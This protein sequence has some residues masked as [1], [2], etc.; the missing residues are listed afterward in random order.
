VKLVTS[1]SIHKFL[2]LLTYSHWYNWLKTVALASPKLLLLVTFII[3]TVKS[4]LGIVKNAS[5]SSSFLFFQRA[6]Y[7]FYAMIKKKCFYS[8]LLGKAQRNLKNQF[9]KQGLK[10]GDI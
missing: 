2:V 5:S 8:L 9:T 4:V 3:M 7:Y 6:L 10:L 1:L